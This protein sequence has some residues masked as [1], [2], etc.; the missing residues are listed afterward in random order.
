MPAIPWNDPAFWTRWQPVLDGVANRFHADGLEAR[1]TIWE[2]LMKRFPNGEVPGPNSSAYIATTLRLETLK[3]FKKRSKSPH[4][5]LFDVPEA[6]Q[7][8]LPDDSSRFPDTIPVDSLLVGLTADERDLVRRRYGLGRERESSSRLAQ[9]LGVTRQAVDK[10]VKRILDLLR[11]QHTN[12]YFDDQ[13][14]S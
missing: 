9:S 6:D 7:P 11:I 8:V 10:R 14:A 4:R 3:F 13:E 5:S 2:V 1:S 12:T